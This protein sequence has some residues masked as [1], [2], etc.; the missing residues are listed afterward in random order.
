MANKDNTVDILNQEL[1]KVS[2]ENQ[3]L[4]FKVADEE[5]GVDVLKVQEII[6]YRKPT[7]MPNAPD[8]VKGVIN[9]RGEVIPMVDLRKK[10]NLELKEYDNFTVVI[11]LEVKS[12]IVGIIVDMVSDMLSFSDEDIQTNL[13]FGS[14]VDMKFIK[15][16]ARIEERLIILLYLDKLLSFEEYKAISTVTESEQE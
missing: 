16:M 3:F 2:A 15:G 7:K 1:T 8:I 9:F 12:K 6:R 4:T 5:Y 14:H 11:I 10:F 13:Q